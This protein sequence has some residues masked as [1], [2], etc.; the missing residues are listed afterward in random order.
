MEFV[1]LRK[2]LLRDR[3]LK[4]PARNWIVEKL[5]LRLWIDWNRHCL[6]KNIRNIDTLIKKT[7]RKIYA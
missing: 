1:S 7:E 3:H 4:L 5:F 2:I 6:K